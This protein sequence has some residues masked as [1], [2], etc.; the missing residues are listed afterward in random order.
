[1]RWIKF[2]KSGTRIENFTQLADL[3]E[4][5]DPYEVDPDVELVLAEVGRV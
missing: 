3:D 2:G 5:V 1:M 4:E